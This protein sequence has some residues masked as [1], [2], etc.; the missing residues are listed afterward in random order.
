MMRLVTLAMLVIIWKS[1]GERGI[2]HSKFARSLDCGYTQW[3]SWSSCS[4]SC[5]EGVR[6]RTR[7][8]LTQ[9]KIFC[10]STHESKHCFVSFCPSYLTWPRIHF[11]GKL[12][13]DVATAN[14]VRC[15]YENEEFSPAELKNSY[16]ALRRE[17]GTHTQYKFRT[18]CWN[19]DGTNQIYFQDTF[20]TSLCTSPQNCSTND[21]I[22]GSQ[23][24]ETNRAVMIDLNVDF[25][26]SPGIF[27]LKVS[28]PGILQGAYLYSSP[29]AP[30]GRLAKVTDKTVGFA[31]AAMSRYKSKLVNVTWHDHHYERLFKNASELSM[32]FVYDL[33]N[34]ISLEGRI[35]GTI[36]LSSHDDPLQTTA[37]RTIYPSRS[38][39]GF[40][41]FY[42]HSTMYTLTIDLSLSIIGRQDE[43][44]SASDTG[45]LDLAILMTRKT[46]CRY[47]LFDDL[48][49]CI[50]SGH[51]SKLAWRWI[52]TD[53]EISRRIGNDGSWYNTYGG[54]MDISIKHLDAT[55]RRLLQNHRLVV[56]QTLPDGRV[57]TYMKE[58][59]KGIVIGLKSN[60]IVRLNPG[61][62]H[63]L[64][65]FVSSFGKPVKNAQ[66][67]IFKV[68]NFLSNAD[69]GRPSC[70]RSL[71]IPDDA[72]QI[73]PGDLNNSLTDKNGEIKMTLTALKDPG[74]IRGCGL[75]GQIYPLE[76]FVRYKSKRGIITFADAGVGARYPSDEHK[77]DFN[78]MT[79][80]PAVHIYNSVKEKTC[81]SWNDIK[82]IF[83]QYY[84]LYPAM[85]KNGIIDLHS[86]DSV[87]K[88][89]RMLKVA[90]FETDFYDARYMP[91][92]RDL[93]S[94]KRKL[95]W[96][97]MKCGMKR[98]TTFSK[99]KEKVC[100]EKSIQKN[101]KDVRRLLHKAVML[102][103]S[104]IPPYFTAWLSLKTEYGRNKEVADILKSV[105]NEE[106]LHMS[107]AGNILNAVG[108]IVNMTD[109]SK[110]PDYPNNLA[111]GDSYEL[112]PN[113]LVSLEPFSIGLVRDI[114]TEIEK[115]QDNE[116]KKMMHLLAKIWKLL[117]S[118]HDNKDTS[119][120]TSMNM[121]ILLKEISR[122]E[123]N[124]PNLNTST[125]GSTLN[126]SNANEA[127]LGAW[128]SL[129]DFAAQKLTE[130]TESNGKT[131]G[132]FYTIIAL[133]MASL[134][135][136]IHIKRLKRKGNSD[137]MNT[138]FTGAY[139]KQL[140]MSHWYQQGDH[141]ITG[142]DEVNRGVLHRLQVIDS[143]AINRAENDVVVKDSK[144]T[145]TRPTLFEV[146][147]LRTALEAIVEIVYQGEGGSDCSPFVTEP[148][149]YGR[150]RGKDHG[151]ELSHYYRFQEIVNGRKLVKLSNPPLWNDLHC[152]NFSKE[153]S[154]CPNLLKTG[155]MYCYA[156]E[157]IA[158]F[159]DGVWPIL[160]NP[161]DGQ[162]RKGTKAYNFHH[163]FNLLYTR[164]LF[165]IEE[166]FSGNPSN[167]KNCMS[168]MY[169]LTI[170]G[171][172]L[173]RTPLRVPGN[174]T[175]I[176]LGTT[177]DNGCP[178]WS[179]VREKSFRAGLPLRL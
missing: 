29:P 13:A 85:W 56:L 150:K 16:I 52:T 36:G 60:S 141:S 157:K 8:C 58:N 127:E 73:K 138:L 92:T 100:T 65:G 69:C 139:N 154:S 114:F 38:I 130:V 104:T 113:V 158:F 30:T 37:T 51:D 72:L 78:T 172:R 77:A 107:L 18:N 131:I 134:E 17:T 161:S 81:P 135:A 132:K 31:I 148:R 22:V 42:V 97:W 45:K 83:I 2:Y 41:P 9:N 108:G 54:I 111:S 71:G 4:I 88:K 129:G 115:P 44:F 80:S 1:D 121:K 119:H 142:N 48:T 49:M 117:P 79:F 66:F 93:S 126:L 15:A 67:N 57:S 151:S 167:I 143:N 75:D 89:S 164:L 86:Y 87:V 59:P 33:Y 146:S 96:N 5:G 110:L 105:F 149:L 133:K 25:Q 103:L 32:T 163:Q 102:E 91:T 64:K 140:N 124:E 136:C 120:M 55:T 165:C 106:M 90:L 39:G 74:N 112:N 61:E 35:S 98:T 99:E 7:K 14:N 23:V 152:L 82:D 171:K 116:G 6:T 128:K 123:K 62:N 95:I 145:A 43:S 176:E 173:V 10:D 170:T 70:N 169:D 101:L 177:R 122:I 68:K 47:F 137:T 153:H 11:S 175:T 155:E 26:Y 28:I 168:L 174:S 118:T 109:I 159:D 144:L 166:T 156:G 179:F 27:G 34:Q 94:G 162:Y 178:T 21:P 46:F 12:V 84:N 19:A 3:S 50:K 147:N 160:K 53:G 63:V 20:V 76:L 40:A 24:I 125:Y